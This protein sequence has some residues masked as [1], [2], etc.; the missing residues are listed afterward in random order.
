MRQ[1][2]GEVRESRQ[3]AEWRMLL[4]VGLDVF[5]VVDRQLGDVVEAPDVARLD[6]GLF[7]Q[8]LIEWV[9]P[10]DLHDLEE[11]LVLQGAD[12]V[13]RPLVDRV[14]EDVGHRIALIESIPVHCLV[15]DRQGAF[16]GFCVLCACAASACFTLSCSRSAAMAFL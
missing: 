8:S 16:H 4:L 14:G 2:L 12:A 7:P 6:T 11:A 13:R 5:R 1:M 3:H 9:L 15:I 10:A